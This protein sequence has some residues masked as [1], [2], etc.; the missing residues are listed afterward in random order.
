MRSLSSEKML[1]Q[2]EHER[3][4]KQKGNLAPS[5]CHA[6]SMSPERSWD[7]HLFP[8]SSTPSLLHKR[9]LLDCLGTVWEKES[10]TGQW[11]LLG[12]APF[13]RVQCLQVLDTREIPPPFFAHPFF[14]FL[15]VHPTLCE[16]SFFPKIPSFWHL[17]STLSSRKRQPGAGFWARFWRG[18]PHGK[19][20][21]IPFFFLVRE[22]R[23]VPKSPRVTKKSRF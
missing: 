16:A 5:P 15:P 4:E 7:C 11:G 12:K 1:L 17:R 10:W 13:K 9:L 3:I 14:L 6:P 18:S 22:R 19:K 21:K 2:K 23:W 20:R 8:G